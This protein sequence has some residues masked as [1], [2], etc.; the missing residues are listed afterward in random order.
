MAVGISTRGVAALG[1]TTHAAVKDSPTDRTCG[2]S[3]APA[4]GA[5]GPTPG[6]PG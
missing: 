6:A 4:P 1:S 3:A 5:T 2:T